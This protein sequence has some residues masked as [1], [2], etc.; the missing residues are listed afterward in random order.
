VRQEPASQRFP[1]GGSAEHHGTSQQLASRASAR[2][3]PAPHRGIRNPQ[4]SASAERSFLRYLGI[5]PHH[6]YRFA[7][8]DSPH[9]L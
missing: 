6:V 3:F 4:K 8:I 7:Q 9:A 1:L 5:H 2:E